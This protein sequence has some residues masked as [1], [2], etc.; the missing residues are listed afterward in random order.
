MNDQIIPDQTE[1]KI[2][3][4]ILF[5]PDLISEYKLTADLFGLECNKTVF[6]AVSD[7]ISENNELILTKVQNELTAPLFDYL[8]ELLDNYVS[9][10]DFEYNYSLLIEAAQTRRINEFI[11][12]W[13][14]G[15]ITADQLISS[16]KETSEKRP[17]REDS[18]ID[19]DEI[20][21]VLT[22]KNQILKSQRFG[23]LYKYLQIERNTLNLISATTGTGKS[24]FALNLFEDF[25][26][27]QDIKPVYFNLE[28][29]KKTVLKRLAAIG[30]EVPLSNIGPDW[31]D[32]DRSKVNIYID[33]LYDLGFTKNSIQNGS[34]TYE[35]I[36]TILARICRQNKNMHIVAFVDLLSHVKGANGI[37]ERERLAQI[38]SYLHSLTKDL[39]VT[40]FL[41]QQ[42][43]R[44]SYATKSPSI[45]HLKGTAQ[46]V[47]DAD[48]V[49][50]L[51]DL[52]KR[53]GYEKD[54]THYIALKPVKCRNSGAGLSKL[55]QVQTAT[56]KFKPA[57][58]PPAW[59]K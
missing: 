47:E 42:L 20:M 31:D 45:Q 26:Y 40:I 37:T 46:T 25:I 38:S 8:N 23:F 9:A 24:S 36:G 50:I 5:R 10:A 53:C 17:D 59:Y 54:L 7:A 14:G 55:F 39:N 29:N 11:T 48:T 19:P 2:L 49:L 13:Q 43:N 58:T 27:S 16:I 44:E 4:T 35:E 30:T 1:Q 12:L 18:R 33:E 6:S 56:Q 52:S 32:W 57:T 41:L 21:E 51:D 28:M 15:N 3:G 22:A 34:K